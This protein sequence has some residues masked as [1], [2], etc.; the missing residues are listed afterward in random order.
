[1]S[2]LDFLF[3]SNFHNLKNYCNLCNIPQIT[4]I[5]IEIITHNNNIN[6]L[7]CQIVAHMMPDLPNMDLDRDLEQFKEFFENPAFRADGLKIYPTLVIRGT[8]LYE[9]WKT[10]RYKSYPPSTLVDLIANILGMVPPWTRVYRYELCV[11]V[12]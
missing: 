10:G 7:P 5:L 6:R 8:G 11:N 9:L 3:L 1:M 12:G 2:L 4:H